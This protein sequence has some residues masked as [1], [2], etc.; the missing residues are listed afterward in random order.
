MHHFSFPKQ[1]RLDQ[2]STLC[3]QTIPACFYYN[4]STGV[5]AMKHLEF[6]I[7]FPTR[8]LDLEIT[9]L[10]QCNLSRSLGGELVTGSTLAACST[11]KCLDRWKTSAWAEDR[12]YGVQEIRGGTDIHQGRKKVRMFT[13]DDFYFQYEHVGNSYNRDRFESL[14]RCAIDCC[15][16]VNGTTRSIIPKSTI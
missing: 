3:L 10:V 14:R 7:Q 15:L 4:A 1:S 9:W 6:Q 2:A 12:I 16:L 5:K 8:V 13:L 11:V